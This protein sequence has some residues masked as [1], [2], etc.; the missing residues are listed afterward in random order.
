[1]T[2]QL[3]LVQEPPT[4]FVTIGGPSY[5]LQVDARHAASIAA[6]VGLLPSFDEELGV[7]VRVRNYDYEHD[8]IL[9]WAREE[10][11]LRSMASIDDIL[12]TVDSDCW[13]HHEPSRE[14]ALAIVEACQLLS[15]PNCRIAIVGALVAQ[16]DGDVNAWEWIHKDECDTLPFLDAKPCKGHKVRDHQGPRLSR[17]PTMQKRVFAVGSA[18][19]VHNLRWYR[20]TAASLPNESH[21]KVGGALPWYQTTRKGDKR[22]LSE[23]VWHCQIVN[24]LG[25]QVWVDPRM[26]IFHGPQAGME[27]AR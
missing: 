23:D 16:R 18:F 22:H 6:L 26:R 11:L 9:P 2:M 27:H 3:Q 17:K 8:A 13:P 14:T 25:G 1:M 21:P 5:R 10:I 24:Q 15:T 4:V 7:R 20:D 12:L 19:C